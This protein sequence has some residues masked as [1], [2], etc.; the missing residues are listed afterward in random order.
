MSSNGTSPDEKMEIKLRA[1]SKISNLEKTR[2]ARGMTQQQLSEKS[3]VSIYTIQAFERLARNINGT[4]IEHLLDFCIALECQ[5]EDIIEDS[6]VIEKA[7]KVR[8]ISPAEISDEDVSAYAYPR[9]LLRDIFSD[10]DKVAACVDSENTLEYLFQQLP[11]NW[12]DIL[13]LRYK[14]KY[15]LANIGNEYHI[16]RSRAGQIIESALGKLREQEHVDCLLMGVPAYQ[17][18]CEKMQYQASLQKANRRLS[19]V[20]IDELNLSG[21]AYNCLMRAGFDTVG[22]AA[23]L[24]FNNLCALKNMGE[25]AANEVLQKIKAFAEK[26]N[27]AGI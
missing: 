10:E 15:T 5:I 12:G 2:V 19:E 16:T 13:K 1:E 22:K 23:E 20:P 7:K 27:S 26:R 24:D 6:D 9:D 17:Q 25:P 18:H 3:G 11:D 21:R 8:E 4:G 14:R